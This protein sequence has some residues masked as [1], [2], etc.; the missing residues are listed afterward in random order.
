MAFTLKLLNGDA[1]GA[2][3]RFVPNLAV[4]AFPYSDRN[5]RA[6]IQIED[7]SQCNSLVT[8]DNSYLGCIHKIWERL[9]QDLVEK[10]AAFGWLKITKQCKLHITG[11][12]I[13]KN[14]LKEIRKNNK[15]S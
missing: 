15:I 1:R 8:F 12:E 9:P 6:G 4:H 2:L 11:K 3:K 5:T 7:R 13:K 14:D 10:G